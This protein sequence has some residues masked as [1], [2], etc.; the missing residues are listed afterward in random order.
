MCSYVL[1]AGD[2]TAARSIIA[3]KHDEDKASLLAFDAA[4]LRAD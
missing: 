4:K 3:Y 1:L 2:C